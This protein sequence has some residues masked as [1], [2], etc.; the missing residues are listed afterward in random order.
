MTGL[1]VSSMP[2]AG[3]MNLITKDFN[4]KFIKGDPKSSL[5]SDYLMIV[6][7]GQGDSERPFR[8]FNWE[9]GIDGLNLLLLN[10]PK[11][12]SSGYSWYD[13]PPKQDEQV[14]QL[15]KKLVKLIGTLE[16]M[17]WSSRKIFI[18][19]F[20]QGA[21]VGSDL[22]LHYPKV[23]AGFIGVSGY[24]HFYPRWRQKMQPS[25]TPFCLLHG[26]SDKILPL[27]ETLYGARKLQS[28]GLQIDWAESN[29]GHLMDEKETDRVGAWVK[30]RCRGGSL[31]SK[32]GFHRIFPVKKPL[33]VARFLARP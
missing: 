27:S 14:L 17:G 8:N 18:F 4:Y 5:G 20:S 22:V 15:R 12:F 31:R 11:R 7:H 16:E 23:L 21:L 29:R 24:F 2:E 19:G 30:A 13:D 6:L 25:K 1:S 32:L 3:P 33:L 9:I 28:L 10:A 26:N